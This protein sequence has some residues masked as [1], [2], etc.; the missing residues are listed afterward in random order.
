M[1]ITYD[2]NPLNTKIELD[3]NE[4]KELWYKIKVEQMEWLL[5]GA[6]FHLT[7]DE[8]DIER[9][10]KEVDPDYYMAEKRGDRSK[11]DS[12]VDDLLGWYIEALVEPHCG[13]C[14]CV[15][16]SC[17]K[18]H[19]EDLLGINTTKGLAQQPEH[20]IFNAFGE[21]PDNDWTKQ[22][23]IHEA[24]E[25]LENYDPKADWE[26]WEAHADRWESEASDAAKWLKTYRDEHFPVV[27]PT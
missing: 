3:E 27:D 24:I 26:G 19:A 23:N 21:G 6:H 5:F 25:Y 17:D 10:L 14:T 9:A 1:K 8:V 13:D 2:E 4:K 16:T 20:H 11:L 22:R 18:C 15:P 12:R 7:L